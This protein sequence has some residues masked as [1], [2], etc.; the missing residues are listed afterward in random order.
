MAHVLIVTLGPIQDFI[1]AARRTRDLWFGS[2]LLSELS[3]AT[4]QAMADECGIEALVFPGVLRRKELHTE[5][6]TSVANKIVVRVPDGLDPASVAKRG[7]ARMSDRL[8]LLCKEAF[9]KIGAPYFER[10]TAEDQVR[11][12]IEYAWVSAPEAGPDGYAEARRKAEELLAARKNTRLWGKVTWGAAVPKSSIDGERESVLHED[13]FDKVGKDGG[14]TPEQIRK[15]YGVGPAERICGVGLLKR[16]GIR[17]E[18]KY[19]H[20]FLSTGHLAAWPL[21]QRLKK[22]APGEDLKE[23]WQEYLNVLKRFGVKLED[24][25]IVQGQGWQHFLFEKYDGSLL[26]EN[27]LSEL[28]EEYV[29]TGQL[30]EALRAARV[31]LARFLEK[32]GVTTPLPYYAILVA[33]GDKMG[34]AIEHQSTFKGHQDLSRALDQ[35]AQRVR[36]LVEGNHGGE[37]VYAGGDDVLAFVP[38]H[39]AVGC[40]RALAQEFQKKLS[41]FPVGEDNQTPTLSAGIGISHFLDPLRSALNLARKAEALAKEKRNSL[42]VIVDKRSGPP[43]EVKGKWGDLDER[44]GTYV[45]M[46]RND[47]VP[48]GAAYELRELGRLL[49]K[50]SETEKASLVELVRKEAERILRRQQPQHGAEKELAEPVL[51]RLVD[52]VKE[53]DLNEVADS[54]IVARLL[55]EAWEEADPTQPG[56][57]AP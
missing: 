6:N 55:A 19:A 32:L 42:A 9:D 15:R 46:H 50:A 54:L 56:G 12:L 41:G 18:A 20:R 29:P 33:D 52:D 4:A 44:L 40:A 7:K 38:L 39:Q 26:F 21:Y 30:P 24:Q 8:T 57:S 45:T 34:K 37:L 31:A 36:T 14:L 1:A 22:L 2:W 28:L 17:E 10:R 16:H 27:R 25:E 13:L 51:K 49:D 35:F 43:V 11:D 47:W 3:K 48:D 23:P 53:L 5:S